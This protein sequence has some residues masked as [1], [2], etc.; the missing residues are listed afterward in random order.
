MSSYRHDPLP[1]QWVVDKLQ[2]LGPI[3]DVQICSV[4]V[5]NIPIQYNKKDNNQFFFNTISTHITI[6][7]ISSV[8]YLT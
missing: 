5:N 4:C 2:D 7:L 8:F 3:R 1:F 6:N